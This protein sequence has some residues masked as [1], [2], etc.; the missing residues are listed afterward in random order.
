MARTPSGNDDAPVTEQTSFEGEAAPGEK[1]KRT[2]APRGSGSDKSKLESPVSQDAIKHALYRIFSTLARFPFR[3]TA[4]FTEAEFS[5]AADDLWRLVNQV[6]PLR[7]FF[8]V[9][10]PVIGVLGLADKVQK[11]REGMPP[12]PPKPVSVYDDPDQPN[13]RV[14]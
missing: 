14:A 3:S 1:P 13:L 8:N 5:D 9:I 6:P 4:T 12:K 10:A 2:R 11:V 7:I